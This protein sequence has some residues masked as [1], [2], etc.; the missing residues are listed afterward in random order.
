[1]WFQTAWDALTT[2]LQIDLTLTF[3]RYQINP[4][5]ARLA[6]LG[7]LVAF[8]FLLAAALAVKMALEFPLTEDPDPEG[9][10]TYARHLQSSWTL[11][12]HRRPPVYPAILALVDKVGSASV[13]VE[14]F[15]LHIALTVAF[16]SVAGLFVCRT[17][18]FLTALLF[19]ST[20][21]I[22]GSYFI[23]M[24]SLM[25]SDIVL[26]I[27]Y[28][29]VLLCAW[30]A[31]RAKGF[32][33]YLWLLAISVAVFVGQGVH[34]SFDKRL[35]LVAAVAVFLWGAHDL[36]LRVSTGR[37]QR[38]LGLSAAAVLLSISG[39][40]IGAATL[41]NQLLLPNREPTP[42]VD[43]DEWLKLPTNYYGMW[44]TIVQLTCLPPASNP[45]SLDLQLEQA[46]DAVSSRM[47]YR[48]ERHRLAS[49][50]I[51]SPYEP[52]RRFF[53][54]NGREVPLDSWRARA[55]AH[56]AKFVGCSLSELKTQY[57]RI[58]RDITPW[59]PLGE[60]IFNVQGWPAPTD[61]LRDRLFWKW[62]I[63]FI[64]TEPVDAS[65]QTLLF[66][67]IVEL[68]K[69]IAV[70]GSMVL[71]TLLIDRRLGLMAG[72]IVL[73][74]GVGWLLAA[75]LINSAETRYLMPTLPYIALAQAVA[76]TAVLRW[77]AQRLS[78]FVRARRQPA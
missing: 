72:S 74:S 57:H 19:A 9:F 12:E 32:S 73:L 38:F 16:V 24:S 59:R 22:G 44:W 55:W 20:F 34:A 76:G 30:F 31:L 37:Q 46:K 56:P 64:G 62:G 51:G 14:A 27:L 52:L 58:I 8:V 26:T 21:L 39:V 4:R 45:S 5:T 48:I 10:V 60:K 25:L 7:S 36:L 41:S 67:G 17:F 28:W 70:I 15:Y 69:A 1:M 18:G 54:Q 29:M 53:E 42:Y 47:G 78:G 33:R 61:S 77:N 49:L 63:N 11:L 2:A 65:A 13:Q 40:T 71:G 3:A 66:A 35:L 23:W 75:S 68:L 50:N 43:L 6:R